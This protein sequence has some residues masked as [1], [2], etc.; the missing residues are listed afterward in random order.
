MSTKDASSIWSND[1]VSL[2]NKKHKYAFYIHTITDI[3]IIMRYFIYA[4][5]I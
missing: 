1:F 4:R 2:R 5:I 3:L